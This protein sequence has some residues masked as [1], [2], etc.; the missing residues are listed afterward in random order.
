MRAKIGPHFAKKSLT[1]A[2]K[3]AKIACV[4]VLRTRNEWAF[5]SVG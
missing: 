1:M 3:N 5:S 4:M 2:D